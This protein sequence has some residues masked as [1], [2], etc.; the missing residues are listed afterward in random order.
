MA[1]DMNSSQKDKYKQ[2]L[3]IC[4]NMLILLREMQIKTRW[5]TIFYLTDWQRL[6]NVIT[7]CA[8]KDIRKQVLSYLA[9]D[10]IC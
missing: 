6:R 10:G 5:D 2:L 4:K 7:Y 1:K 3:Q 8:G 9:C